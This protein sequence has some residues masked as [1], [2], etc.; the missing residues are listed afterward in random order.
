MWDFLP[1]AAEQAAQPT[2]DSNKPKIKI[3]AWIFPVEPNTA[4]VAG[5]LSIFKVHVQADANAAAAGLVQSCELSDEQ[6][7]NLKKWINSQRE[8]LMLAMPNMLVLDGEQARMSTLADHKYIQGYKEPNEA[9]AAP[10]PIYDTVAAGTIVDVTPTLMPHQQIRLKLKYKLTGI[11]KTEKKVYKPGYE[12]EIPLIDRL[13]LENVISV[14]AGRTVLMPLGGMMKPSDNAA[15]RQRLIY[16]LAKATVIP[17]NPDPNSLPAGKRITTTSIPVGGKVDTFLAD[18]SPTAVAFRE[19]LKEVKKEHDQ[20]EPLP[21]GISGETQR[22]RVIDAYEKAIAIMPGA[23]PVPNMLVRMAYLWNSPAVA[24]AEPNKA[25]EIYQRIID[26]NPTDHKAVL[27]AFSGLAYSYR[28]KK[29]YDKAIVWYK[30]IL[31]Y[32]LPTDAEP[33]LKSFAETLKQE[34]MQHIKGLDVA[35]VRGVD[36][37]SVGDPNQ[38]PASSIQ[39]PA[40]SMQPVSDPNFKKQSDSKTQ[41]WAGCHLYE[42]SDVKLDYETRMLIKNLLGEKTADNISSDKTASAGTVL[43]NLAHNKEVSDQQIAAVAGLLTQRGYLKIVEQSKVS[44][45]KGQEANSVG[46]EQKHFT[47]FDQSWTKALAITASLKPGISTRGVIQKYFDY[48]GGFRVG[49]K[50]GITYCFME[51]RCIKID[52]VFRH[53]DPNTLVRRIDPNTLNGPDDIVLSV[54]KPYKE[55]PY[56]D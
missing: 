41:L 33:K 43:T 51:C 52:V 22:Q 48:D 30:A 35:D 32:E 29:E 23:P 56:Y 53:V 37:N 26:D 40:P 17:A 1:V 34:A 8:A 39:N 5:F 47:S 15:T 20:L 14:P 4:A 49:V 12:I 13:E 27:S 44:T 11:A 31:E 10:E 9:G 18:K 2:A 24:P 21:E 16:L 46:A 55:D 3:E 6:V 25:I 19:A 42:V 54:S 38:H 36:A 7:K 45:N 28:L 50:N